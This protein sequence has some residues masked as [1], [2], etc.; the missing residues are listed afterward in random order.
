MQLLEAGR[1]I[2][3]RRQE[4]GL[5]QR[6]LAKLAGV[7][8]ATINQVENG[9]ISDLG[10]SKLT[11]IFRL[12]GLEISTKRAKRRTGALRMASLTVSVSYRRVLGSEELAHALASG[13]IPRELE[14]HISTLLDEA[15]LPL[16]VMAVDEA[17][18]IQKVPPKQI[19]QHLVAWAIQLQSPRGAWA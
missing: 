13:E 8:R 7:S 11:S 1:L 18:R 19:W 6:R 12:L 3:E 15:P 16:I 10:I 5:S 14:A 17:A 2:R 9:S 4:L